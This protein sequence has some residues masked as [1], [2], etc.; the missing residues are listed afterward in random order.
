MIANL[1]AHD[2]FD[3]TLPVGVRLHCAGGQNRG[4]MVA[5]GGKSLFGFFGFNFIGLLGC[6]FA[7]TIL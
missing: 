6:N 2:V 7:A 5:G 4:Q 3:E 1:G